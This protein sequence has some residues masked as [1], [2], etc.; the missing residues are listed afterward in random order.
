MATCLS[1]FRVFAEY[2]GEI[3]MGAKASVAESAGSVMYRVSSR[4]LKIIHPNDMDAR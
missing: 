2:V 4:A 3:R 1:A